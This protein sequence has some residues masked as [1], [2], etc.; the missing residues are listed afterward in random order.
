MFGTR[1]CVK[2]CCKTNNM[3][4]MDAKEDIIR[5]NEN[6]NTFF[7]IQLKLIN[8]HAMNRKVQIHIIDYRN[9]DE[10]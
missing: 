8:N 3:A 9:L 7:G 4:S 10:R 1:A 6:V 5:C 2:V